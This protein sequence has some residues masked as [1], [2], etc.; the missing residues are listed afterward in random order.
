MRV[1]PTTP[2]FEVSDLKQMGYSILHDLDQQELLAPF[3]YNQSWTELRTVLKITLPID[4]YFNLNV[5]DLND[6]RSNDAQIIYGDARTFDVS[7]N[8]VSVAYS[9]IGHTRQIGIGNYEATYDPR[10]IILQLSR[11]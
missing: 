9:L 3:V 1:T 10:V 4:V 5:Y 11:G 6:V 7:N 8:V 2:T